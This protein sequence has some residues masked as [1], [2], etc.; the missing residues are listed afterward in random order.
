MND[1]RISPRKTRAIAAAQ[2][3]VQSCLQLIDWAEEFLASKDA[4]RLHDPEGG[5]STDQRAVLFQIQAE[6]S[7]SLRDRSLEVMAQAE[8]L[9]DFCGRHK[10]ERRLSVT[11]PESGSEESRK[12][13]SICYLYPHI[14]IQELHRAL[15]EATA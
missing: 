9:C 13:C 10:G 7:Q 4:D 12:C 11:N 6:E 15:A 8:N 1:H 14:A 3:R 2:Q 5:L